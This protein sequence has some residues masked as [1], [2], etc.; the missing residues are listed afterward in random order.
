M[1]NVDWV[2]HPFVLKHLTHCLLWIKK[3]FTDDSCLVR[4]ATLL[5]LFIIHKILHLI[6]YSPQNSRILVDRNLQNGHDSFLPH[7]YR[8]TIHCSLI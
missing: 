6:Y 5:G 3:T 8:F 1:I 7:S 2:S 4:A